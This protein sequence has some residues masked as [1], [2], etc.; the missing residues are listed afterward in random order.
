MHNAYNIVV[1]RNVKLHKSLRKVTPRKNSLPESCM[2]PWSQKRGKETQ[3]GFE[4]MVRSG[5]PKKICSLCVVRPLKTKSEKEKRK[6]KKS[7]M[8]THPLKV[9][10]K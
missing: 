4:Q 1:C 6:N 8:G 9:Q 3:V 7:R 10:G 2:S 5:R